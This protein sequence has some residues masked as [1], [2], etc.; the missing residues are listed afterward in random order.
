MD[1]NNMKKYL[2]TGSLTALLAFSAAR[3]SAFAPGYTG[4]RAVI[5]E[6]TAMENRA[7][8]AAVRQQDRMAAA[9]HRAGTMIDGRIASLNALILR[10]QNDTRMSPAE[11]AGLIADTQTAITSLSNLKAKI[12]ADTDAQTLSANM[13]Q[14]VSGY[15][16]YAIFEPKTRLLVTINNLQ[17]AMVDLEA[18]VPQLQNLINT[19]KAEGKDVSGLQMLLNDVS[20]QIQSIN[21]AL[22]SDSAK[23]QAVSTTSNP[24]DARGVFTQV[25]QNLENTVRGS[26]VKIHT[27]IS[28][29]RPLFRRLFLLKSV[30][31][32]A[33]QSAK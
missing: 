29:M 8:G 1:Y 7:T 4:M 18:L 9:I 15:Y 28:Q 3:A 30:P 19:Q 22:A 27:D 31:P 14:I 24:A 20:T 21:S 33:S 32:Q 10:I 17:T 26:V 13:K 12:N 6:G 16:I 11:K 5:R 2:I 23:V 25:R